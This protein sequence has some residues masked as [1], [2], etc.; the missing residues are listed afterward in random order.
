[1]AYGKY[2]YLE[3]RKNFL[4]T[5]LIT[6]IRINFIIYLFYLFIIFFLHDLQK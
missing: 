6:N 4:A 2:M 5:R 3:A 1:M